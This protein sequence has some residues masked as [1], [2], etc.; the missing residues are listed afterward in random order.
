MNKNFNVKKSI[1]NLNDLTNL[2]IKVK[3]GEIFL[4]KDSIEGIRTSIK[5]IT[6]KINEWSN[7][8][9]TIDGDRFC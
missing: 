4:P 3:R 7:T 1:V 9:E 5:D 6:D 8:D 2:L